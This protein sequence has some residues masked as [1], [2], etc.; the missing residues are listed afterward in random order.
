MGVFNK[1]EQLLY[2]LRDTL[3]MYPYTIF[4]GEDSLYDRIKSNYLASRP[5]SHILLSSLIVVTA[6]VF[7]SEDVSAFLRINKTTLIEGVIVGVDENNQLQKLSR[8]NPLVNTNIQLEKDLNELIYQGLIR[9]DEKGQQHPVLADFLELKEGKLYRFK[10]RDNIYWQDG[11]K[12]TTADVKATF[13]LIQQLDQDARTSTL[14]SRAATKMEL[15]I[16]DDQSFEFKLNSSLPTFFEAVSFKILPAH[17]LSDVNVHNINSS[18]PFINRNPVGTGMYRFVSASG[19]TIQ[20]EQYKDYSGPKS[21]I[22]NIKFKMF[23]D[24][25]TAV[26][27]L[28]SGQIHSLTGVST[29]QLRELQTLRH[30]DVVGSNTIYNQYWAMYFNLGDTG[31]EIFKDKKVRQAVSSAI[32]R[33]FILDSLLGYAAEAVG[34]IPP[35]SFAFYADVKRYS[36]DKAAAEKLLDDDGW[37]INAQTG[38]R[39]KN[40]VQLKF[41]LLLVDNPDRTKIADLIQKDLQDIGIGVTIDAESRDDVINQHIIPRS[42]ETVLYGVQTFIDPDRFELFH[43]SQIQHPGLN[44]SSYKSSD[45]VLS[46]IDNKTERVPVVDDALSDA[47]QIVDEKTRAKKYQTFQESIADDVPAVFLFHPVETYAINRRLKNVKLDNINSIEQR[48]DTIA[49]WVISAN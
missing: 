42:F 3:W 15:N 37:K 36:Y 33:K 40:G 35:T 10:L 13:D 20:L 47:R 45:T 18:D 41:S 34:P 19:D 29:D 31:P 4:I 24:E 32:N 17:M 22:L 27:A 16:I 21:S 9:V 49:D 46:V 39:E 23:P 30:I 44:I 26:D 2:G 6:F 48:F 1:I 38:L 25:Q 14:Y 12:L 11:V 8:V 7:V 43:S 28:K 5:F